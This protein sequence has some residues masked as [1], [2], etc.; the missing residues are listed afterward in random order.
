[1]VATSSATDSL[2]FKLI[3][4]ASL[5]SLRGRALGRDRGG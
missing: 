2:V 3:R 1:V 5:V 4:Q